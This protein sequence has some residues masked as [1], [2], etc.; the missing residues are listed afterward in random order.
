M[1]F[2]PLQLFAHVFGVAPF[3]VVQHF[4][5]FRLFLQV[6][7]KLICFETDSLLDVSCRASIPV[8]LCVYVMDQTQTQN[9]TKLHSFL[10]FTSSCCFMFHL[11]TPLFSDHQQL[12]L[13]VQTS[14]FHSLYFFMSWAAQIHRSSN[15]GETSYA[16]KKIIN[17]SASLNGSLCF[18]IALQRLDEVHYSLFTGLID[19]FLKTEKKASHIM[20]WLFLVIIQPCPRSWKYNCTTS[21]KL[22]LH[23]RAC[24]MRSNPGLELVNMFSCTY[25]CC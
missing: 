15:L 18:W 3:S 23:H 12:L 10:L 22:Q 20:L 25:L 4:G 11:N 24:G 5:L 13:R 21:I 1:H 2:C 19:C 9:L 14:F 17:P 7:Y 8:S 16:K 6:L